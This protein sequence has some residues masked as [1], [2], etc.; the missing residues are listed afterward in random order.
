MMPHPERV[1]LPWQWGWMPD[2]MKKNLTTSPW[3]RMFQ[4]AREWCETGGK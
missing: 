1:V 2:Q 3:L 4:N